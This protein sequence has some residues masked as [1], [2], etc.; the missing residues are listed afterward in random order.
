MPSSQKVDCITNLLM[1]SENVL[2]ELVSWSDAVGVQ[3][4]W[5]RLC[6]SGAPG[7]HWVLALA[8]TKLED[9]GHLGQVRG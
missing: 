1:Y 2:C 6:W 5:L 4:L 8:S 9:T 7:R 3:C